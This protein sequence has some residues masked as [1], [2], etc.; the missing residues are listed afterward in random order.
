MLEYLRFLF[1][2]KWYITIEV[3]GISVALAFTIPLLS[4]FS[5]KWEIDHGKDYKHV[6]AVCPVDESFETT[7]GLGRELI[8]AVPEIDRY[9]QVFV[10]GNNAISVG[11]NALSAL[12]IAVSQDFF[13]F[14]DINLSQGS[15]LSL[16]DRKSVLISGSLAAKIGDDAMGKPL[17]CAGEEYI[18][19]GIFDDLHN[20]LLPSTEMIFSIDSPMMDAQWANP[21]GYWENIVTFIRIQDGFKVKDILSKCKDACKNYYSSYYAEHP[22]AMDHI[23]LV[24][25]D[26]ISSNIYNYSL[27]QTWGLSLWAVELFGIILFIF[28]FV[29]Y[30]NLNVALSTKRGKEWALK[31][32]H[33][34]SEKGIRM[35]NFLETLLITSVCFVLGYGLSKYISPVFNSFFN[36]THTLIVLDSSITPGKILFYGVFI[37]LLSAITALIPSKIAKRYSAIDI[38][39]GGYRAQLK[40]DTSSILIGIQC[41]ISI[42]LLSVSILFYAQYKKMADRPRGEMD[43]NV[44]VISGNYPMEALSTAADALRS[45]PFVQA[46]GLSNDCPGD[47]RYSRVTLKSEDGV[48]TSL[49]VIHCDAEAFNAFGFVTETAEKV[50]DGL[51][52]TSSARDIISQDKSG[53]DDGYLASR[54]GAEVKGIVS[55]FVINAEN[56]IPAALKVSDSGEF[57][58]LVISTTGRYDS[59]PEEILGTFRKAFSDPKYDYALPEAAGYIDSYYEKS[60]STTKAILSMMVIYALLALLLTVLGLV[61]MSTYYISLHRKDSAVRKVFGATGSEEIRRHIYQYLKI[62]VAASVIGIILSIIINDAIIM[63]YSYRLN[64]TYWIYIL[65]VIIVAG[66]A[67]LSVYLQ[68]RRAAIKNPVLDL[69]DE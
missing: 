53:I 63:N 50:S 33:G 11:D 36:A 19:N 32:L 61:A 55:D 10:S 54:F 15:P 34:S 7:I 49:Y 37:L 9:A 66:I 51:W 20:S 62:V 67:F 64:S 46:V 29:N 60:L 41:F 13:K 68:A 21:S 42:V 57:N 30:V 26:R 17:T 27:T 45:L 2:N 31:K 52:L 47:G 3:I 39:N 38:V 58:R 16:S 43:G 65:A 4:F 35:A 18:I 28:A 59:Y 23:K 48:S 40:K 14:F 8:E 1:R 69:R 6:Y 22:D 44:F 12:G 25:Y 24:R 56:D 5:D